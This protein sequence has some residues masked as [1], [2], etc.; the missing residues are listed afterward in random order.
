MAQ[1][2][3]NGAARSAAISR[4][5]PRHNVKYRRNMY[6]GGVTTAAEIATA[7]RR[8]IYGGIVV[9]GVMCWRC[10][11]PRYLAGEEMSRAGVKKEGGGHG[12]IKWLA[13]DYDGGGEQ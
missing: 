10:V 12:V 9:S 13:I 2:A 8:I 1:S 4:R 5:K 7:T 6:D 11:A 3:F